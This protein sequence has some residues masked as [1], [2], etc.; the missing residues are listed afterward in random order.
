MQVGHR[1]GGH[2]A[3]GAQKARSANSLGPAGQFTVPKPVHSVKGV[4][5]PKAGSG[6]SLGGVLD[7]GE[8]HLRMDCAHKICT[9]PT[10][11]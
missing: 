6:G 8:A 7:L 1:E 3:G 10:I 4:Q 11:I 2:L 5:M 9:Q